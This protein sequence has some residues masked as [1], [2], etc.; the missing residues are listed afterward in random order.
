MRMVARLLERLV[1]EG[2]SRHFRGSGLAATER[3]G[4]TLPPQVLT[5][6]AVRRRRNVKRGPGPWAGPSRLQL[7]LD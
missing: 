2:G 3:G 1:A 6:N 7:L 4:E 5:W